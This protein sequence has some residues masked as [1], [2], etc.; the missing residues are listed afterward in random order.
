MPLSQNK[1]KGQALNFSKEWAGTSKG[2]AD[3]KPFLV[4]F[5]NIFGVV[6]QGLFINASPPNI[7]SRC[8]PL[9]S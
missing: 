2:E 1:I 7:Q 5:F 9:K 3:A 4:E 8:Q 6:G